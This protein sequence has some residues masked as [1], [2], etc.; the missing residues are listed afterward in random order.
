L[1]ESFGTNWRMLEMQAAIGRIQLTKMPE[2]LAQRNQNA[3]ILTESLLPFTGDEGPLRLPQIGCPSGC[4]SGCQIGCGGAK[5]GVSQPTE[6]QFSCP[7]G[8][9]HAFYK[10]YVFLKPEFLNDGWSRDRIIDAVNQ[11]GVPCYSG[12]CSEVYLEKAFDNTGWRPATRLQNAQALG[13]T[14]I[15][16]MVHPTLTRDQIQQTVETFVNLITISCK[17]MK[18]LVN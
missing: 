8:C 14:A 13:E 10:F 18:I 17:P 9:L 11:A 7:L 16:F 15:M 4:P 6:T 2:W 3:R 5:S 1:H 12:S